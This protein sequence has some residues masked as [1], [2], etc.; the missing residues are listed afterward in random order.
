MTM[1]SS[2]QATS[3]VE[4]SALR[5]RW[6]QK[7]S[8]V[9]ENIF[10]AQSI[11]PTPRSRPFSVPNRAEWQV[12]RTLACLSRRKRRSSRKSSGCC[13]SDV[14]GNLCPCLRS[15]AGVAVEVAVP[16]PST[17]PWCLQ[18]GVTGQPGASAPPPAEQPWTTERTYLWLSHTVEIGLWSWVV[19]WGD[20]GPRSLGTR[21][22]QSQVRAGG[23]EEV[24][25]APAM[26]HARG[27]HSS[28]GFCFVLDRAPPHRRRQRWW[29]TSS[30]TGV[31]LEGFFSGLVTQSEIFLPFLSLS[32]KKKRKTV[33]VRC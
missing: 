13:S 5:A 16:G 17:P 33:S 14:F 28:K 10:L 7:A 21:G 23:H 32:L 24:H 9:V 27:V 26:E 30:S 31:R 1:Q 19:K 29:R 2:V 8:D 6:Q 11:W 4:H 18:S 22:D 15:P 20:A 12:S 3:C 25:D